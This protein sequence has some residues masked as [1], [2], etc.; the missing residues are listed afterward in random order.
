MN[1][2][3]KTMWVNYL[4]TFLSAVAITL[5]IKVVFNPLLTEQ[6][7]QLVQE[8]SLDSPHL[9]VNESELSRLVEHNQFSYIKI[10]NPQ[11]MLPLVYENKQATGIIRLLFS[12]PSTFVVSENSNQI[13]EFKSNNDA[14]FGLLPNI[15]LALY[16]ALIIVSTFIVFNFSHMFKS[17]EI[18]LINEI[19]EIEALPGPYAKVSAL[20]NAQKESFQNK[21]NKQ[22]EKIAGLTQQA[23][24]DNLTGVNNRSSFRK[25]LTE[26]LSAESG[27][28]HA[29]LSI[30]RASELLAINSQQGFMQG[31]LYLENL[32]EIIRKVTYPHKNISIYRISGS[33]FALIALGMSV[34]E[35]QRIAQDLKVLFDQ[36]QAQHKLDSIA[37]N[38]ISSFQSGQ[39]P[40]QVLARTDLALAKAQTEG[41]N[42][43]VFQQSNDNDNQFGQQQWRVVIENIIAKKSVIL[44]HQPVLILPTDMV[45][46]EEIFTR[47]VSDDGHVTPAETVFAMAQRVDMIIKLEQFIIGEVIN[48]C[49]R[50]SDQKS[51]WGINI[52][53]S[54]MQNSSFIVWLERL[55]L[56]DPKVAALLT[57]EMQEELL[58]SNLVS[59]KRV[60]DML[61]RTGTRSAISNFG[62]GIGSF[63]LLR[64]LKPDLVK[65]DSSLIN[66]IELDSANQQ[67][68]RM[69]IDVAHRMD[70]T[71]IAEGVEHLAQKQILETMHIDG[72]QGFLIAR[73]TELKIPGQVNLL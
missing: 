66:N 10:T 62:K 48:Q 60:F 7:E 37:Y 59:S 41:V 15:L 57:F 28:K 5:V 68:I 30:I 42:S 39:K 65:I 2:Y 54:A 71:I 52:S 16:S 64:T 73:P 8:L 67:F 40:E 29:I 56:R 4:F 22:E 50:K 58:D 25:T 46:Y 1:N 63:G 33:D 12:I 36:Y 34:S 72:I 43:W 44:L 24:T 3:K 38:G 23:T 14:L 32:T 11:L 55:L 49:R 9:F 26:I 17:I 35:A 51:R 47:F 6:Q 21:L 61:R 27:Q 45:G 70:C 19:S 31:D 18:A 69:I 53:S 20:L 13:I